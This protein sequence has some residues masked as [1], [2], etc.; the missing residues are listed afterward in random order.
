MT[1]YE[2]EEELRRLIERADIDQLSASVI[3]E[4]LADEQRN[5]WDER[6]R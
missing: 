1:D 4:K 3:L 2:F 6:E 5:E